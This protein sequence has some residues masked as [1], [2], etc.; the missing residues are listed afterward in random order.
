MK[1]GMCDLALACPGGRILFVEVKRVDGELSDEQIE[2]HARLRALG[3]A[4]W[5]CRTVDDLGQKL[6]AFLSAA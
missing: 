6:K 4:V 5:V 1:P 2:V 3:H